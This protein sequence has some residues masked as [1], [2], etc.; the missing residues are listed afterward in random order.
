[1]KMI[2]MCLL[3]LLNAC[4]KK[5]ST[6]EEAGQLYFEKVLVHRDID[7]SY[8]MLSSYAKKKIKRED[9]RAFLNKVYSQPFSSEVLEYEKK[10]RNFKVILVQQKSDK[11]T[12]VGYSTTWLEPYVVAY[13]LRNKDKFKTL[14]EAMK[15]IDARAGTLK[16]L[17]FKLTILKED[18]Q[19]YLNE[20]DIINRF[21]AKIQMLG[22]IANPEEIH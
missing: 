22:K 16:E 13:Y 7:G 6:P 11:K 12:V 19:Y 1:M 10:Y 9:Y 14:E 3:I 4:N 17:N 15:N 20:S 8:E 21:L 18:E 5:A 2:I